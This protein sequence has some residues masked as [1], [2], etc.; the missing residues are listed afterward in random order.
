MIGN[1]P[2]PEPNRDLAD[3]E[4]TGSRQPSRDHDFGRRQLKPEPDREAADI[5]TD[6]QPI[7]PPCDRHDFGRFF[8]LHCNCGHRA[9][10]CLPRAAYGAWD[11][12]C[13]RRRHN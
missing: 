12:S 2:R 6:R 3:D 13:P 4:I 5:G 11:L 9:G 10:L 1:L 7:R 8:Q